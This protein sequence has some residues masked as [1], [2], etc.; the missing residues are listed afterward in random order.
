MK[1]LVADDDA[2]ACLVAQAVVERLGHE[3][4]IASDGDIAWELYSSYQPDVLITDWMMPGMT[5][6]ELCRAVRGKPAPGYT[7]IVLLT[8]LTS[9][10]EMLSGIEAGADDYIVKPLDAF[11]LQARF[12]VAERVTSLHAE[13]ARYR[14]ELAELANTDPLTQLFNRRKLEADLAVLHEHSTRYR[15]SYS[16]ALCDIDFFKAY[17]DTY[18][19]QAGDRVLES[20]A[21]VLRQVMRHGDG[22]YRYG[23]EEFLL[24]LPEQTEKE[25]TMAVNR[26]LAAVEA[27]RIDHVGGP[28]GVL[29]VSAGI[30][31]FEPE[32]G[33]A[34]ETVLRRADVALYDAKASGR[35][36]LA[37]A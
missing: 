30:A 16:L 17:N 3:C 19:H 24:V 7:Y 33:D 29:T 9:R 20:V 23:G 1:V 26:F 31:T 8:S 35:N 18:G 6:L 13:L 12:V 25:S 36:R 37:L 28:G 5:G 21:S 14:A 27:E 11:T 15:R 2:G 4:V 10:E 34:V 32:S 22:L